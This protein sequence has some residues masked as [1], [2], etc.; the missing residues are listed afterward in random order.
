M[1]D[2]AQSVHAE[3]EYIEPFHRVRKVQHAAGICS[4][5]PSLDHTIRIPY[6]LLF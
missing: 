1:A 6:N 2:F 5:N 4:T 3:T